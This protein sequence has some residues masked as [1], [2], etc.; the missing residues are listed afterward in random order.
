MRK[1]IFCNIVLAPLKNHNSHG[2]LFSFA[3]IIYRSIQ[4]R[5][6]EAIAQNVSLGYELGVDNLRGLYVE[7]DLLKRENELLK[8]TEQGTS[9]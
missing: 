2:T 4:E 5:L 9:R 3:R 1:F 8:E 7:R 6:R